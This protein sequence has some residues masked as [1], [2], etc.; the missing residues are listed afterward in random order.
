LKN[1]QVLGMVDG[2]NVT[3]SVK[4]GKVM[5]GDANNSFRSGSKWNYSRD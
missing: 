4:D 2:N 1:G 5:I 3:F